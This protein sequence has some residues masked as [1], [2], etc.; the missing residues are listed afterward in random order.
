MEIKQSFVYLEQAG[1]AVG[2]FHNHEEAKLMVME[3][4]TGDLWL[5]EKEA[6]KV[7]ADNQEYQYSI[8]YDEVNLYEKSES[9]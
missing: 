3:I 8:Y 6:I 4:L 7:I 1:N 9:E 5:S 2:L